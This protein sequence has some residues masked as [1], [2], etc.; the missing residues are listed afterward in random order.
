MFR[1]LLFALL[2]RINLLLFTLFLRLRRQN[3]AIDTFVLFGL[4]LS[5]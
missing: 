1:F 3:S 4:Q 2:F 5:V